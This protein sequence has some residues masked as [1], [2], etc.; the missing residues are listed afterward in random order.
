MK[1]LRDEIRLR[2]DRRGGFNFIW[3]GTPKIS[4]ELCEDF[5]VRSTISLNIRVAIL[6][7]EHKEVQSGWS[8]LDFFYPM[9]WRRASQMRSICSF[10]LRWSGGREVMWAQNEVRNSCCPTIS[11]VHNEF[12]LWT[13]DF[14]LPVFTFSL[15]FNFLSRF[16]ALFF[17]PYIAVGRY[18]IATP[19]L[20]SSL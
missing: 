17:L 10:A 15:I 13:L 3:G 4:S 20:E 7:Y 5:I 16:S 2:R 12:E 1:S 18:S 19:C 6:Y 9:N 11:S 14:F 8:R